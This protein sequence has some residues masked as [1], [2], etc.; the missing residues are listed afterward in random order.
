MKQLRQTLRAWGA[1]VIAPLALT[2]IALSPIVLAPSAFANVTP[3]GAGN[4]TDA[5][6]P[7]GYKC[8]TDHGY[9]M[10]N[11]GLVKPG[12][13]S[14]NPIGSPTPIYPQLVVPAADKH[15]MTHRWWGSIS[16]M[17]EMKVGDPNGAGYITPDPMTA[18]IT[19]R[20]VRIMGIPGGLRTNPTATQYSIPDPFNEVFDGIAVGN[21]DYSNLEAYLKANPNIHK[22][23]T[24][25]VR[26]LH[27]GAE[28]IPLEIYAF[29]NA[30]AWAAY[31]NIQADIF[32]HIFAVITEFDLRVYQQPSGYD[33]R[34]LQR[35]VP[36]SA[37]P[38]SQ[39][40]NVT[41]TTVEARPAD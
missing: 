5:P 21:S 14:C 26:Q 3:Y 27:P 28:G 15:T 23:M 32:D 4:I 8:A 24:C 6:N 31:E 22:T 35:A 36:V 12:V 38:G 39:S 13:S 33:L 18:R 9:W 19:D 10:Y 20:G 7:A 41:P 2:S 1:G 40:T 17:G 34:Q 11:A 16:F 29:T 25:M 37:L 30:T